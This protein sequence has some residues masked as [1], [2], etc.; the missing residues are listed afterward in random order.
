MNLSAI[1]RNVVVFCGGIA[2]ASYY[3]AILMTGIS[4]RRLRILFFLS[5]RRSGIATD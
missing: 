4:E 2:K 3:I 5:N 1:A